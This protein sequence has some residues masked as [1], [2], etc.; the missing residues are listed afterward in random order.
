MRTLLGLRWAPVHPWQRSPC[1]PPTWRLQGWQRANPGVR[2]LLGI[3]PNGQVSQ[4]N[5]RIG[6]GAM[7]DRLAE[8][9]RADVF[10]GLLDGYDSMLASTFSHA[11][12][13]RRRIGQRALVAQPLESR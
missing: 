1:M 5:W 10:Y 12:A 3:D 6:P 11:Q 7:G 9:E 2:I 13:T 4:A 8:E